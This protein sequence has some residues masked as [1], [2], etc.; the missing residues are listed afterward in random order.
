MGRYF[1]NETK[2]KIGFSSNRSYV[3]NQTIFGFARADISPLEDDA[4]IQLLTSDE[5]H[6]LIY[7]PREYDIHRGQYHIPWADK[8]RG[9]PISEVNDCFIKIPK[10]H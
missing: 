1:C 9:Q 8:S 5:V 6:L 10:F 4:S 3:G 2:T 7:Q